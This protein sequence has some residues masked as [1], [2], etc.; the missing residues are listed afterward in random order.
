MNLSTFNINKN[1][2][3]F[4]FSTPIII[5]QGLI[6]CKYFYQVENHNI[7]IFIPSLISAIFS[8]YLLF[9]SILKT[10]KKEKET[11]KINVLKN[12]FRVI[13]IAF[14]I[15]LITLLLLFI[16]SK[17]GIHDYAAYL[18]QWDIVNQ[19]LDPWIGTDNAYLPIHNLFAPLA[20]INSSIPKILFFCVFIIPMYLSS[21]RKIN[22][23]RDLD[24]ISKIKIFFIFA[25]TPFC[26]V[27]TSLYGL[28]DVLVTGLIVFSLYF[29]TLKKKK[30][31]SLISGFSLAIA[32]MVK[33]YPIFISP[34]FILRNGKKDI[35]FFTSYLL[36]L[37]CIVI[38]SI[39]IWGKSTYIPIFFAVERHSKHLSFFNFSKK[40]LGINLDT[41]SIY[42]MGLVL[43][44]TLFYVY[45][46]NIDLL[47]AV[48]LTLALAFS[49]YKVGH[50]QFFLIFFAISPMV[51]RYIY[52]RNLISNSRL[53]K[54]YLLWICFLNS[55]QTFYLL[56]C[57]MSKGFSFYL[58]GLAPV[59]Y[60]FFSIFMIFELKKLLKKQPEAL[61][62][63]IFTPKKDRA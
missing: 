61:S 21:V 45:K 54:S 48:V 22:F 28:N 41:Y 12:D 16:A 2:Y 47:P 7:F 33:I 9:T 10:L 32:T 17:N 58:R 19:G 57:N 5:F 37:I 59:P 4:I 6:T 26:V 49:F 52:D 25:F 40:I 46:K 30:L 14:Y 51:I 56:T 44:I 3:L 23:K 13:K 43:F 63:Y 34:L 38:T 24:N 35:T 15:Y 42:L 11:P 27:F 39:I 53:L 1:F 36:S 62:S 55:Y 8:S 20:A 31:N 18:K 29:S 60:I 50:P